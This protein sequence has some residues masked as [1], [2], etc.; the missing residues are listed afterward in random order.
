MGGHREKRIRYCE[1]STVMALKTSHRLPKSKIREKKIQ[2][3]A[4]YKYAE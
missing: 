4:N 1:V 2:V 3:I